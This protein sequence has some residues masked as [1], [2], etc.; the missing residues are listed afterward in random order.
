MRNNALPAFVM[1][2][3]RDIARH[4][5]ELYLQRGRADGFDRDD[6]VR[7]ERELKAPGHRSEPGAPG[8]GRGTIRLG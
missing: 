4:A 8:N 6:W 7:A 2:S 5:Y 3:V 1:V